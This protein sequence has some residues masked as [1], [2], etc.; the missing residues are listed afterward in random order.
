M[1]AQAV[2]GRLPP[3]TSRE[4]G[5]D[6]RSEL[7]RL[8]IAVRLFVGEFHRDGGVDSQQKAAKKRIEEAL[9]IQGRSPAVRKGRDATLPRIRRD[10]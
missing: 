4:G 10:E 3:V 7:R 6:G 5:F 9:K 8:A 1:A 2:N